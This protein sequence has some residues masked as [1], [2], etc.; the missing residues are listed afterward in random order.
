MAN[1]PKLY[2]AGMFLALTACASSPL[3]RRQMVLYS[4]DAMAE[5]GAATYRR[6]Q[7]EIP[8]SNNRDE[9]TFVNCVA[10]HVVNA[11]DAADREAVEWEVTVFNDA[12]ANAFAL[13]GGKI[14]VYN[15]L[16]DVAINQHQLA[17]VMA[18]E[19]G[20]VLANH[21]NERASQ[22]TLR[23][24]GVLAAQVLGVSGTTLQALDLGTQL[25]IFLPFNRT[26]ESEADSIGVMLMAQAGFDPRES[27]RL[28]QNMSANNPNNP[29]EL[30]STHPS[31]S[32]RMT[33][34]AALMSSA[35]ILRESAI[36]RGANPDC[37]R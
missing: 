28:W 25:G 18:H 34:L 1:I 26:Q 24:A 32:S 23:N 21:S 17:A 4:D 11:L 27:I 14:G 9:I 5:R 15:G 33:E 13:P 3:D 35:A 8:R 2:L 36:N 10:G 20:H 16:L 12:Q 29:P 30:L 22:S 7:Q 6:M 19:V 37:V 31:P